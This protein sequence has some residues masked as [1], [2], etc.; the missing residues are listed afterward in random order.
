MYRERYVA[1]IDI[2][3]FSE[4]VEKSIR[5]RDLFST[6]RAIL[7]SRAITANSKRPDEVRSY[8]FS[9]SI[10]ISTINDTEGLKE[11]IESVRLTCYRLLHDWILTRGGITKGKL[12]EDGKAVFGPGFIRAYHIEKGIAVYPRILMDRCIYREVKKISY[13]KSHFRRD[14]DA[15]YHL[16]IL[17]LGPFLE[18]NLGDV[19]VGNN[20]TQ[21]IV[22][23]KEE[24]LNNIKQFIEEGLGKQK[25]NKSIFKKY[26]WMAMYFNSFLRK[27]KDFNITAIKLRHLK[28]LL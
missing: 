21:N 26:A 4:H 5:D 28:E 17:K 20:K 18:S 14:Y 8:Q 27:S 22:N 6:L 1:F 16:D 25:A 7:S 9:D 19:P 12:Y 10:V 3:G 2:L 15:R 23:T 24:W 11:I 13:D